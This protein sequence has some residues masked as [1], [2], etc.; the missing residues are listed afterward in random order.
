MVKQGV[1]GLYLDSSSHKLKKPKVRIV[2][3]KYLVFV[4]INGVEL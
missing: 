3:Q 4:L 2:N 1:I